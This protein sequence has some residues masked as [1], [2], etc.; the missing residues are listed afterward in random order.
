MKLRP[1]CI[2][3]I[4]QRA[5]L[6]KCD[7]ICGENRYYREQAGKCGGKNPHSSQMEMSTDIIIK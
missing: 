5:G 3:F 6:I 7:D 4:I 2:Q 1:T